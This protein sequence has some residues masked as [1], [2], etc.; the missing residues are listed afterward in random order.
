MADEYGR[1]GTCRSKVGC[2][3]IE[4][5]C[6]NRIVPACGTL[7]DAFFSHRNSR[8]SPLFV[9]CSTPPDQVTLP[10]MYFSNSLCCFTANRSDFSLCCPT[11]MLCCGNK[12][13]FLHVMAQSVLLLLLSQ[14][15]KTGV[16]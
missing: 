7:G 11:L 13:A 8:I 2:E 6:T 9:Q 15:I 5:P 16:V 1:P 14:A 4:D 3:A 12:F 10:I